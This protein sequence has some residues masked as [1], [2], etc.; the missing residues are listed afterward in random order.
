[1]AKKFQP[2]HPSRAGEFTAAATAHHMG[3]HEFA[4]Y[5]QAHPGNFDTKRS[6][7]AAFVHATESSKWNNGKRPG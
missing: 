2:V 7:Q 4:D 6:H 3:V 1:M 5:V